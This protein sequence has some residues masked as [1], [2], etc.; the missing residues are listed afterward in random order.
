MGTIFFNKAHMEKIFKLK[1]LNFFVSNFKFRMYDFGFKLS[2]KFQRNDND[3]GKIL[4]LFRKSN[5]IYFAILLFN[6]YQY[7]NLLNKT[8]L[9]KGK[10]NTFFLSKMRLNIVLIVS[11]TALVHLKYLTV[12]NLSK[13]FYFNHMFK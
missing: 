3:Y 9:S 1:L 10:K 5:Y 2:W 12:S 11:T 7:V 6:F 8:Y 4:T 13:K